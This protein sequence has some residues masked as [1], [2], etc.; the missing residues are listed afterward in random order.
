MEKRY[1][2]LFR[3]KL[4]TS[5]SL[6]PWSKKVFGKLFLSFATPNCVKSSSRQT[7]LFREKTVYFL[8]QK[9]QRL[10]RNKKTNISEILQLLQYLSWRTRDLGSACTKQIDGRRFDDKLETIKWDRSIAS[11][12]MELYDRIQRRNYSVQ[13]SLFRRYQLC[14]QLLS[15]TVV[16]TF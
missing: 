2:C 6:K 11:I 10:A 16:C 8:Q 7:S 9:Y 5:F 12:C 14:L 3:S 15:G 1:F 13:R 4:V